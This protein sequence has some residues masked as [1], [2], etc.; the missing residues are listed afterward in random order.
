[1]LINKSSIS[2]DHDKGRI[3]N[4]RGAFRT[5]VAALNDAPVSDQPVKSLLTICGDI[6]GQFHDLADLFRIGG[7]YGPIARIDLKVPPRPPGYA[8]VEFL[9]PEEPLQVH[10]QRFLRKWL[11]HPL[12]DIEELNQRLASDISE[13]TVLGLLAQLHQLIVRPFLSFLVYSVKRL[14]YCYFH[15]YNPPEKKKFK[16][17]C[18]YYWAS[19]FEWRFM[20]WQLDK[21]V[22]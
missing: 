16:W 13:R 4:D 8:F 18:G 17:L 11:C 7:N 9:E 12:K 10:T 3:T 14:W 5:P 19:V 6:H 2:D 21:D 22:R 20:Q 1:M 15:V